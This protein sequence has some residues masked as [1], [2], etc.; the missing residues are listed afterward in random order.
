MNLLLESNSLWDRRQVSLTSL[1]G[2][3]DWDCSVGFTMGLKKPE[4]FYS[5]LNKSLQGTY[6][7]DL[8]QQ[9]KSFY[10]WRLMCV[11]PGQTYSVHR[12]AFPGKINKRIHIPITTNPGAFF[13]FYDQLPADGVVASVSFHSLIPGTV[14]EMNTSNYHTAV[15]HGNV[16]RYHIVGVRYEDIR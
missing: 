15:N 16:S 12:D 11:F 3:D 14:Y 13:C 1:A 6:M 10:R 4:R 7:G 9:Y 5:V 8:I 2:A